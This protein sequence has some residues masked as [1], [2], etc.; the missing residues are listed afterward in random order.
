MVFARDAASSM[1]VTCMTALKG[2]C[3]SSSPFEPSAVDRELLNNVYTYKTTL[4][5]I[6]RFGVGGP[7]AQ[8]SQTNWYYTHTH[9]E[10]PKRANNQTYTKTN[11]QTDKQT[12]KQTNKLKKLTNRQTDKQT[13]RQTNK[14]TN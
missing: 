4:W 8:Q 10:T 14:Q 13:N 9:T 3:D 12:N 6:R 5:V 7:D 2:A 1:A 11:R